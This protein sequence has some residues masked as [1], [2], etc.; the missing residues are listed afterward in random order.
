MKQEPVPGREQGGLRAGRQPSSITG[1]LPNEFD[2]QPHFCRGE[3]GMWHWI[4]TDGRS[5]QLIVSRETF[6]NI[7]DC[8][9]DAI[10]YLKSIRASRE[11]ER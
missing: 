10:R 2:A 5:G 11:Q 4:W 8:E 7:N 3:Y 1:S 6:S 9:R